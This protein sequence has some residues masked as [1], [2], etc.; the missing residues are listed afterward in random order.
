MRGEVAPLRVDDRPLLDGR[1]SSR[2]G[3]FLKGLYGLGQVELSA[4]A[5]SCLQEK[6]VLGMNENVASIELAPPASTD[7]DSGV[8][9]R[10]IRNV[11]RSE[12][13]IWA[14]ENGRRVRFL[15]DR[16]GY[17]T[18]VAG[19]QSP[20]TSHRSPVAGR[21]SPVTGD[22]SPFTGGLSPVTSRR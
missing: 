8:R 12:G 22:R 13:G 21:R 3:F 5:F 18:L 19:H 4:A 10:N 7:A 14:D 16:F 1:I 20:V 6:P 17:K 15:D 11:A 2:L 9:S